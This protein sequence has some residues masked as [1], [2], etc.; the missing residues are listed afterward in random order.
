MAE[1]DYVL[2]SGA[3]LHVTVAPFADANALV[4]ALA[5]C[6]K[7]IPLGSNPMS[8]DVGLLKDVLI[9]AVASPEVDMAL[10]ACMGRASYN[11]MRIVPG[12]FDDPK[13]GDQIRQD[14]YEICWKVIEANCAPF[15]AKAFSVLKA[16]LGGATSSP[17]PK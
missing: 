14:Y 1:Q 7:G 15:F 9:E 12:L 5:K 2:S 6:A 13:A 4:K 16:R 3:R 10:K 8:A 11:D 17:G